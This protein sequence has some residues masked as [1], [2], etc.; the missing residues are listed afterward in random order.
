MLILLFASAFNTICAQSVPH[1]K[2]L[3]Q[4][5]AEN[6][7]DTVKADLLL[8]LG[9]Y[10]LNKP[11]ELTSDMDSAFL[12]NKQARQLSTTLKYTAGISQSM[13]LESQV[14]REKGD[15]IKAKKLTQHA[16]QY[17]QKY[18]LLKQTAD[19]WLALSDFYGIE[20]DE[21][22][23]RIK[24]TEMAIPLYERAGYKKEQADSLKS[25]G[26]YYHL[27][28]DNAKA[29]KLLEQ[30]LNIYTSIRYKEIQGVYDLLGYLN[31]RTGNDVLA[32]KYG[33]LAV[34]TAGQV[35]D[36]TMQLCTIY[37]RLAITYN[38]LKKAD[39]A[40]Y[41]YQKALGVAQRYKAVDAIQQIKFN[42]II[43]MMGIHKPGQSLKELTEVVTKYPP[44]QNTRLKITSL[45]LF[46]KIYMDMKQLPKAKRFVDSLLY[47]YTDFGKEFGYAPFV[48]EPIIRYYFLSGQLAGAYPY[49]KTNDS[50]ARLRHN[51]TTIAANELMWS[52]VDSVSG[53]LTG[54]LQHYQ[55]YKKVSDSL[56]NIDQKK[57]IS[58]LQYQ[59]DIDN[60]NRDILVL[61]Q[62]GLL[63][64]NRINRE[65]AIRNIVLGGLVILM[66]FLGLVYSRY[67]VKKRSNILLTQKQNE[68]NN[69]NQVLVKLLNEKE[70][71]LKEIHHRVKNNLQ[72]V[73]S[74]LNTQSAYLENE[75]ALQAIKNSQH[76]MHA[77]SL[78]HQ[79][80]YQSDNVGT[81]DMS[82]YIHE[83]V[84][85]LSESF[86]RDKNVVMNI[87][88][89]P[90]KLAVSQ[91]VPL[92]LILNEAISN[93]IKYA[94]K[95]TGKGSIDIKLQPLQNEKYLLCIADNGRGLPDGFDPYNI[96]SLG[97]SLMLGLCQQLDGEFFL[98]NSSGLRVC[99]TFKAMEF[100]NLGAEIS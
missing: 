17:A 97:M 45:S 6:K 90:V 47:Y 58:T 48:N 12:F 28:A 61:K 72:I 29:L 18:H 62:N 22:A 2:T 100:N 37:N 82:V 4:K 70:W 53:K 77:M 81:I 56:K 14:Y 84:E 44:N 54:A 27:Q 23:E 93:A 52:K 35:K 40:Y 92:G 25:L 86:N 24:L 33:L 60:K 91:A 57:Q 34:K 64:K 16:L 30:S 88:V 55:Q 69:Q 98:E 32:L 67:N 46:A 3:R 43:L 42:Q 41:Y 83:L 13:V 59:F 1:L 68:I 73:I 31:A 79:K 95:E 9:R 74:L 21:L 8:E 87:N 50:L 7:A 94:F 39:E 5:L 80:L 51:L 26:D 99:V 63:Q 71:L 49:L 96:S 89:I 36:T 38:G 78:I 76:R 85:Y 10:Y 15:N 20:N 11:G 75:D 19:S 66:I 65:M